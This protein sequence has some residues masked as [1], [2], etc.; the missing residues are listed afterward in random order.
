MTPLFGP[1]ERRVESA[2]RQQESLASAQLMPLSGFYRIAAPTADL[3]KIQKDLLEEDLFDGVYIKPPVE[4]PEEINTMEAVADAPPSS[5]ADFSA[6]QIYLAAAPDGVDA[7]WAW[8]QAGG[9]GHDVRIVDLEGNWRFTHEDLMQK[10]GGVIGGSVINDLGWRNHG[11]AVIGEYGGDINGFGVQGICADAITSAVSFSG[12]GTAGAI[13]LAASRLRAG[14]ILLLELHRPG[15]RHNFQGR[16][17]QRGYVAIEWWP[18]DFAAI[19]NA[20]RQGI[21]VVEAAGNGA[22]DLDDAIYETPGL[23]FP[24]DWTNSYRRSNRDSGAIVVGAGAPPPGT[25]GR[26][27]GPDRSRLGFSN[28]GA[29]I[30]A[31]GWGREV[32]TCGYGDLQGGQNEDLWYTDTFSGTSSASPIVVGTVGC[33]QGMARARGRAVFTPAEIKDAL[34]TTGSPQRA[35]PGR[36]SSQRIG[37]RPDIRALAQSLFP[38]GG[39]KM[40]AAFRR[41]IES[42]RPLEVRAFVDISPQLVA[43]HT[44]GVL[45]GGL[46]SA[47]SLRNGAVNLEHMVILFRFS[48]MAGQAIEIA[49]PVGGGRYRY[50]GSIAADGLGQLFVDEGFSSTGSDNFDLIAEIQGIET[51]FAFNPALQRYQQA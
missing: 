6:R 22:E 51:R 4:P 39:N 20:S 3:E 32:T 25:H 14:D 5:T 41:E 44:T 37:N 26:N 24:S 28:Y 13:N 15:P 45:Q 23:G 35:A 50:W 33:I 10:Q 49:G 7:R 34:R 31:Q 8:T 36:P 48:S 27:H 12:L 40:R 30:D 47:Q 21:I 38:S 11:T 19:L 43:A 29:L 16:S 1:S 46:V 2:V 17:D 9:R 18:D 42:W